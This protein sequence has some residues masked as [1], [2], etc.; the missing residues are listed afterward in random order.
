[1]QEKRVLILVL[2]TEKDFYGNL[3]RASVDTWDREEIKG[4]ET[5]FYFGR[6]TQPS[7]DKV[8]FTPVDDDY[9]NM[10]RK[11]LSAFEYALAHRQFDYVFRAN[12]SL[13]VNKPGL[14]RYVQDKPETGLALGVV[15]DCGKFKD[16]TFPFMWGPSYLLSRD[17][18]GKV[19]ANRDLWK[20]DITDD[21][22]IS[23]LLRQIDVPLDNRGSMASIALKNGGYE[24]V[25]YENGAGGGAFMTDLAELP[26]RLP[27]QFAFRVKDDADRNNDIR[28]MRELH[29]AFSKQ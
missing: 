19:V 5:I 8:L 4:V 2:S 28:L 12:A 18:V 29:A 25:Y 22:S 1:M 21:L 15:A 26:Q 27:D 17:V 20:H 3:Y 6:S 24:F 7:T 16:E 23:Y 14:L 10:G 9:W 13:Y 11:T